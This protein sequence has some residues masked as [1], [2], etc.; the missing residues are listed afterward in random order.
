MT[1]AE[2]LCWCY[3]CL[4]TCVHMRVYVHMSTCIYMEEPVEDGDQGRGGVG[5]QKQAFTLDTGQER[6]QKE[7]GQVK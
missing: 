3:T 7:N 4:C 6:A 1:T 2:L 5:A